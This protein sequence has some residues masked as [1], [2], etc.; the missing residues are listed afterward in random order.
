[1]SDD[2][3]TNDDGDLGDF[4]GG[5]GGGYPAI[6]WKFAK[7]GTSWSGYLLPA[8]G[9]DTLDAPAYKTVMQ[10]ESDGT[11]KRYDDGKPMKQAEINVLTEFRSMELMSERAQERYTDEGTKDDGA[12]RQFIK[13]PRKDIPANAGSSA[14]EFSKA[15]RGARV[16]RPQVGALVKQTLVKRVE[17]GGKTNNY[18]A[19]EYTAPTPE[20]LAKVKAFLDAKDSAPAAVVQEE[21]PF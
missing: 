15:L 10:T 17:A 12:R 3:N 8:T 20:S 19:W 2:F 18:I 9:Y 14:L 21:P 5:G 16:Q 4:F 7:A 11:P 6:S 1:M 13:G